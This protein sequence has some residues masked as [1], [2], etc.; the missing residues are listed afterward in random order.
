[1]A[2]A[3]VA[4][5]VAQAGDVLLNAA[6]KRAFHRHAAVEDRHDARDLVF[7]QLLGALLAIDPASFRIALLF[8]RPTPNRYVRLIQAGL[9][10]GKSTPAIRGMSYS[11]SECRIPSAECR[12]YS[13]ASHA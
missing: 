8:V 12:F 11:N 6:P 10:F 4:A 2:A 9:S 7:R 5:D 1:V 13:I 3:T